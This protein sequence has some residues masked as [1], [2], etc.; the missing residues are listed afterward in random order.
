ATRPIAPRETRGAWDRRPSGRGDYP[1][2][3]PRQPVP[4]E[5]SEW[6]RQPP[7]PS[8]ERRSRRRVIL[9]VSL[10]LL[11]VLLLPGALALATGLRDYSELKMVGLSGMRHLLAAKSILT[12]QTTGTESGVGD[13]C[14]APS[15]P[16]SAGGSQDDSLFAGGLPDADAVKAAHG[17]LQ[18]AP[19]GFARLPKR[20]N[21]PEWV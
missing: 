2:A 19:G 5:A 16:S 15:G 3:S 8:G 6:R 4:A 10:G 20:L 1:I 17:E 12:G 9:L 11:L 18:A 13:A 7:A 21:Q 14:A